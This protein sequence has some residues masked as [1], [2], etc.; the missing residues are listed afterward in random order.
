MP[1]LLLWLHNVQS[2]LTSILDLHL[3]I[4]IHSNTQYSPHKY[5]AMASHPLKD[6]R[7]AVKSSTLNLLFSN[8]CSVS[9]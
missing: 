3:N 5:L 2:Y 1:M 8:R 9:M 4:D 6:I 7:L